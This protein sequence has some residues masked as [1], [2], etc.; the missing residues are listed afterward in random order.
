M[1]CWALVRIEVTYDTVAKPVKWERHARKAR[2]KRQIRKRVAGP[3]EPFL[4]LRRHGTAPSRAEP[5]GPLGA[6]EVA[7]DGLPSLLG[8]SLRS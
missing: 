6:L 7:P 3:R 4:D 8:A 2:Q 5:V 1:R